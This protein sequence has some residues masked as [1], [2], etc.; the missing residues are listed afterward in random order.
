MFNNHGSEDTQQ[1]N[2][3]LSA[4]SN[5]IIWT[6]E[7]GLTGGRIG[8]YVIDG[9]NGD[10]FSKHGQ[11]TNP[12]GT[13]GDQNTRKNPQ[14]FTNDRNPNLHGVAKEDDSSDYTIYWS[15]VEGSRL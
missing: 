4:D 11:A 9:E 8:V 10:I 6:T 1:K 2:V 5:Q 14:V 15:G 7:D 12:F 13:F 3:V